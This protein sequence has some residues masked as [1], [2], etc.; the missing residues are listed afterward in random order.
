MLLGPPAR[1]AVVALSL[2]AAAL[3]FFVFTTGAVFAPADRAISLA[4][5]TR[6]GAE[7]PGSFIAEAAQRLLHD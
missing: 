3:A 7:L 5:W 4:Y 1:R 6:I 2:A